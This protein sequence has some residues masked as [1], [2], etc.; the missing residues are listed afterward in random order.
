LEKFIM[1]NPQ[2]ILDFARG[3]SAPGIEDLHLKLLSRQANKRKALLEIL[4]E[5]LEVYANAQIVS[6]LRG[7]RT[8]DIDARPDLLRA[9][10]TTRAHKRSRAG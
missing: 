3:L 9:G 4:D 6:V 2:E 7:A 8:I 1:P 5:L 10:E